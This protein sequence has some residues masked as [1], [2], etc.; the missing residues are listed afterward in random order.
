VVHLK[1]LPVP[2]YPAD[3]KVLSRVVAAGFNQRRKM[4]RASL[5]GLSPDI[6]AHLA[7]AGIAPTDRAET[8][9]IE[10]FCALARSLASEATLPPRA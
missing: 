1:A 7:A 3:P 5:R 8:V 6:E 9:P 10:A 4:L 2:R